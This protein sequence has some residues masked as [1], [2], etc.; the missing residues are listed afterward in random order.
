MRTTRHVPG[1]GIGQLIDAGL[2]V[3]DLI[4]ARLVL[5]ETSPGVSVEQVLGFTEA[6]LIIP[7]DV[8]T[9]PCAV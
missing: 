1:F 5:R 2:V 6:D 9:M 8:P 4:D 7:G 3:I